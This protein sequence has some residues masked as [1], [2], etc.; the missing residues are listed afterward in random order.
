MLSAS[1]AGVA[2]NSIL[3]LGSAVVVVD[4]SANVL[5]SYLAFTS[6]ELVGSSAFFHSK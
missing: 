3:S 5:P 1:S 2:I 6:N 4:L